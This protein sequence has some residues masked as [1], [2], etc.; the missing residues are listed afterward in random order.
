VLV[1][2][3]EHG[4]VELPKPPVDSVEGMLTHEIERLKPERP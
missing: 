4:Q 3:R 1:P 2:S